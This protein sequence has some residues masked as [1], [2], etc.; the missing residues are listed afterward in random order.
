M[1]STS[2]FVAFYGSMWKVYSTYRELE[3][4]L[5]KNGLSSELLVGF[6]AG[7]CRGKYYLQC[8]NKFEYVPYS[9]QDDIQYAAAKKK[10][11]LEA[12]M[13]I[14]FQYFVNSIRSSYEHIGNENLQTSSLYYIKGVLYRFLLLKNIIEIINFHIKSH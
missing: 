13:G 12:Y 11:S 4:K 1:P 8:I 9:M 14:Q 10:M 6:F 7:L 5:T 3:P 2:R